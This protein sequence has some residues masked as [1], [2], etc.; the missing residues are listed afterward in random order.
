MT[1]EQLVYFVLGSLAG[2]VIAFLATALHFRSKVAGLAVAAERVPELERK[3]GSLRVELE[4]ARIMIR[5]LETRLE[6][7]RESHKARIK[8]LTNF[9]K[10]LDHKFESLAN[11]ALGTNN[12]IFME[13]A[14]AKFEI[15]AKSSSNELGKRGKEIETVVQPLDKSLAKLESVV[16]EIERERE[17]AYRV[18][19]Q[20]LRDMAEGQTGLR[21]ETARLVQALRQPKTRG[22]WG[23]IQLRNVF[24]LAGMTEHVDFEEQPTIDGQESRLRPDAIIRLSGGRSLIVDAKTPL[25]AYLEAIEATDQETREGLVLKHVQ[26]VRSHIRGLGSKEYWKNLQET[27]DFVVMFIPGEVFFAAAIEREPD[28]FE[29]AVNHRVL[30]CTPMTLIALV[31]AIAFGW[32]QE[33][34]VE[35]VRKIEKQGRDLYDRLKVFGQ[36]MDDLGKS[37][38]QAVNRY[39][40]GVGSLESRLLPAARQFEQLGIGEVG[41]TPE[42]NPVEH[43]TRTLQAKEFKGQVA[44]NGNSK[45]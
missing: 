22:R 9:G 34:L 25:N 23:E 28:L 37:L 45:D 27:P 44:E 16:R 1:S 41:S 18:I 6:T 32:Q 36:H 13:Q 12:K 11:R 29:E 39:N 8:E 26:Q 21:T 35:N 30:I 33:K 20:Q 3:V 40:K 31:K 17:G 10:E 43:T 5:E 42:L 2:A 19:T 15:L 4:N 7:E 38:G 24:D 14:A